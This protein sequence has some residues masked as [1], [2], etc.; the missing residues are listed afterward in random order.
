MC[1]MDYRIAEGR[2]RCETCVLY[3]PVFGDTMYGSCRR[4]APV[5]VVFG[6]VEDRWAETHFPRVNAKDVCGEFTGEYIPDEVPFA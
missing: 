1:E 5:L 2:A 4:H 6:P 3:A